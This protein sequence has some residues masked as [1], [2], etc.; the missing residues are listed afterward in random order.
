MHHDNSYDSMRLKIEL[1]F[2]VIAISLRFRSVVG[3]C[4]SLLA[5]AAIEIQYLLWY[6]DTK[7]WLREMQVSDFSQ[8][9]IP[10]E[11]QHFLGI[12]RANAWDFALFAF[13]T[14]LFIWQVRV[15]IALIASARRRKLSA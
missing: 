1:A 3:F 12:Y 7:R 4:I 15:V 11:W 2:L 6:L 8:L 9:P 10:G 5:T 13:T 14:G